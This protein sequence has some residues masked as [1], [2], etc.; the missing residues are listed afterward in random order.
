MAELH[1]TKRKS[2]G[3]ITRLTDNVN[4]TGLH[5]MTA[6]QGKG[7]DRNGAINM[8]YILYYR[9]WTIKMELN[10]ILCS[11]ETTG[12]GVKDGAKASS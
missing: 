1:N 4:R 8:G 3:V 5:H 9:M 11:F 2:E 7:L 6:M 10:V 12:N